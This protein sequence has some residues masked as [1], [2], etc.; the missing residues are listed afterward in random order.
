MMELTK[1]N[2][3]LGHPLPDDKENPSIHPTVKRHPK[4]WCKRQAGNGVPTR[5]LEMALSL[6]LAGEDF[7]GELFQA[8]EIDQAFYAERDIAA[9][10]AERKKREGPSGHPAAG[11]RHGHRPRGGQP[12]R[13]QQDRPAARGQGARQHLPLPA[14]WRPSAGPA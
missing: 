11:G 10:A 4:Y 1:E 13:D 9:H 5:M 8:A 6:G 14:W 2:F 12:L 7:D 3:G